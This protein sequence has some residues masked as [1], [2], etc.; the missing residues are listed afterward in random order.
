MIKKAAK[1]PVCKS[2]IPFWLHLFYAD[3]SGL[4]C[5]T[6]NSLLGHTFGVK[7]IKYSLLAVVVISL[8][9]HEFLWWVVFVASLL[10]LLY[11]QLCSRFKII[12]ES[13]KQ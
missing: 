1:C 8:S 7:I 2:S 4:M 9:Q 12:F 11:V 5:P 13:K 10:L 3:I 6:C